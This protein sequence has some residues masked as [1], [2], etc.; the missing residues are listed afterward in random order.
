MRLGN[1]KTLL[2]FSYAM[3]N[4]DKITCLLQAFEV[5]DLVR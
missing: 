3:F 4:D 1:N 2:N 5:I